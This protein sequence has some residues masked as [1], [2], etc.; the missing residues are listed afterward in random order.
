MH[1]ASIKSCLVLVILLTACEQRD[2]HTFPEILDDYYYLDDQ[3]ISSLSA[4]IH[5]VTLDQI[6][7]MALQPLTPYLASLAVSTD[8][9]TFAVHYQAGV[10]FEFVQPSL[11]ITI[12]DS[13]KVD[14]LQLVRNGINQMENGFQ[15]TISGSVEIL[16]SFLESLLRPDP[17]EYR[18]L[19]TSH[20]GDTLVVAYDHDNLSYTNKYIGNVMIGTQNSPGNQV[21]AR[22]EYIPIHSRLLMKHVEVSM[23]R[24]ELHTQMVVDLEYPDPTGFLFPEKITLQVESSFA[25][26]STSSN[27]EY[28]F[29]D[30]WV[31]NLD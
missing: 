17:D 3:N 11:K 15:Q 24:S 7:D 25:G 8:L 21:V 31:S 28:Q 4:S 26:Q 10:G 27:L 14:D 18:N 22:T 1:S 29:T 9:D 2:R 30:V 13:A 16:R 12:T 5:S 19:V 20:H 23:D 6:L